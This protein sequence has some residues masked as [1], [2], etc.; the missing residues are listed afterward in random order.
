MNI[1][2]LRSGLIDS[3]TLELLP[4]KVIFD[5]FSIRTPRGF[6]VLH[7]GKEF[8]RERDDLALEIKGKETSSVLL[9]R[10]STGGK[11]AVREFVVLVGETSAG[12]FGIETE[13]ESYKKIVFKGRQAI[14]VDG[15][16]AS[17]GGESPPF[18]AIGFE[19]GKYYYIINS[20]IRSGSGEWDP[21]PW[22][23]TNTFQCG[24]D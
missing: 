9:Y 20:V 11:V 18:R 19:C 21:L 23:M 17:P 24:D 4:E 1:E 16:W 14:V 3:V 13:I 6:D 8:T 22:K 12:A 15:T 5:G 10:M 2:D 7:R